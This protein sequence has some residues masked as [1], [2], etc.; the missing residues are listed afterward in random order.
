[1]MWRPQCLHGQEKY[2][3]QVPE[4]VDGVFNFRSVEVGKNPM[5]IHDV[6]FSGQ[7]PQKMS[8]SG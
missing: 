8:L 4:I 5:T 2:G 3:G 1:M 6:L 7:C